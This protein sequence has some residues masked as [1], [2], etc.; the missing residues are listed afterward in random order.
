MSG[1]TNR[2]CQRSRRNPHGRSRSHSQWGS[3]IL[4]IILQ[5]VAGSPA[6]PE[7]VVQTTFSLAFHIRVA[8]VLFILLGSIGLFI[9]HIGWIGPDGVTAFVLAFA[10]Q[11]CSAERLTRQPSLSLSSPRTTPRFSCLSLDPQL[12]LSWELLACSVACW[13]HH[14]GDCPLPSKPVT[15]LECGDAANRVTDPDKWAAGPAPR[16]PG[17]GD[18]DRCWLLGQGWALW[19]SQQDALWQA[20]TDAR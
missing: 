1:G 18:P 7:N 13:I 20:A 10:G 5:V 17:R 15:S 2:S 3:P 9:R 8:A 16:P 11:P 19:S 4:Y 6:D 12:V 14:V